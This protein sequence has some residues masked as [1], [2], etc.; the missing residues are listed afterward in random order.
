MEEKRIIILGSTGSIGT[1]TVEVIEH[2]NQLAARGEGSLRYRVV[3]LAAG[4][5]VDSIC[6]E[7][8]RRRETYGISY[9]TVLDDGQNN[10]VE[11]FAPVVARLAGK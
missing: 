11:A 10:M 7:L 1:Q 6:D 3:G 2:L 9:I 8:Q 5:S 4:R